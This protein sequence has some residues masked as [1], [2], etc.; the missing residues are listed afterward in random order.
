MARNSGLLLLALGAGAL[1]AA[2]YLDK[3]AK[4]EGQIQRQFARQFATQPIA[5]VSSGSPGPGPSPSP[6]PISI[7]GGG[8]APVTPGGFDPYAVQRINEIVNQ[9]RQTSEVQGGLDRCQRLKTAIAVLQAAAQ[10][11]QD[12]ARKD[13]IM[14]K[15]AEL[16]AQAVGC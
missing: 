3:A 15:V 12:P 14:A 13:A 7:G 9:A 8:G 6:S 11:V 5:P 4:R 1:G 10:G 16:E 2:L